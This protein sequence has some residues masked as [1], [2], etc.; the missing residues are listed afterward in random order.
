[1]KIALLAAHPD[2][3]RGHGHH[4]RALALQQALEARGHEVRRQPWEAADLTI[5]DQPEDWPL[6]PGAI[7]ID[8]VGDIYFPDKTVVSGLEY[9]ILRPEFLQKRPAERLPIDALNAPWAYHHSIPE[10]AWRKDRPGV[11]LGVPSP[12][13]VMEK[14][15]VIVT[16]PCMTAL[17]GYCLGRHVELM[18]AQNSGQRRLLAKLESSGTRRF[19]AID[20]LGAERVALVIE[21]YALATADQA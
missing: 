15:A 12:W 7:A 20:G 13:L 5:T 21:T 14:A 11:T 17:E 19:D 16:P 6:V 8:E 4:Y 2:R 3:G 18:P 10:S 9:I 1:M